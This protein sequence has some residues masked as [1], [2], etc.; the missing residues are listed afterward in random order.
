MA[1][2]PSS[3]GGVMGEW[4]YKFRTSLLLTG[5][6]INYLLHASNGLWVDDFWDHSAVIT[7][8]IRHPWN[9][10]HPQLG[11]EIPHVFFT[12]YSLLVAMVA[13]LC[14]LSS[15]EALSLFGVLNAALLFYGLS[16]YIES[17]SIQYKSATFFYSVLLILFFWGVDPWHYSGFFHSHILNF[18][19]PYPSAFATGLVFL[20]F[21]ISEKYHSLRKLRY[22]VLLFVISWVVILTHAVAFVFLGAGLLGGAVSSKRGQINHVIALSIVMMLVLICALQW[23]YYPFGTL[24]RGASDVYHQSNKGVYENIIKATWPIL[25]SIPLIILELFHKKNQQLSITIMFLL[26]VYIF[27][28]WFEKYSYGRVISY[29]AMLIQIMIAIKIAF[30][31]A[32]L[33]SNQTV[34]KIV[35]VA[36]F[37]LFLCGTIGKFNSAA[38]RF[39]T[40]LNSVYLNRVILN[41]YTFSQYSFLTKTIQPDDVV[42]ANVRSSWIIPSFGAKVIT[43]ALP[44]AFVVDHEDRIRNVNS[45][46]S[47]K[48]TSETRKLIIKKYQP[49]YVF[50]NK[51]QDKNWLEIGE[52]LLNSEVGKLIYE[53]ETVAL[54]E[55][56]LTLLNSGNKVRDQ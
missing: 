42:L 4:L 28:W 30:W 25:L 27:A 31:D 23:P 16:R 54:Y 26:A 19:L 50:I 2:K 41:Q 47:E 18:S 6:F 46:Y 22:L 53:D 7:E 56:D 3:K 9:P 49:K 12:P 48:T 36:I 5:V 29:I 21:A 52:E 17:L 14:H 43:L 45:F 10:K 24:V 38:S 44:H 35:P 1:L 40:V 34:K 13:K 39:L 15:I 20:A 11:S 55:I 32:Q 37:T 51:T 33:F 8:L